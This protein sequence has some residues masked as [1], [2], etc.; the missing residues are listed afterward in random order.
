MDEITK[1]IFVAFRD[2]REQQVNGYFEL[3]SKGEQVLTISNGRNLIIVPWHRVLKC[4]EA[5][6]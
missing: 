1:K 5:L 2:E 3:V 6:D 4:R